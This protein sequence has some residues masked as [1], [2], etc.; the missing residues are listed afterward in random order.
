LGEKLALRIKFGGSWYFIISGF[1]FLSFCKTINSLPLF[2]YHRVIL[3]SNLFFFSSGTSSAIYS[4]GPGRVEL[5][6]DA[7][8]RTLFREIKDLVEVDLSIEH[9]VLESRKKLEQ[10]LEQ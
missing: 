4:Y 10:E 6:Q 9:E 5:K 2:I 8:Y 1:V 7:I 3:S